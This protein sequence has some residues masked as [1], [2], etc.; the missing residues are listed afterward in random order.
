YLGPDTYLFTRL[1]AIAAAA[2]EAALPTFA[3][4]EAA[5]EIDGVL[6]GLVSRYFEIGQ[7]TGHK[8]A[9]ILRDRVAPRDIPIETLKRFSFVVR[10]D[11]A[12]QIR[13]LPPVAMFNY[14]EMR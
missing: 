13:F 7:F 1:K 10:L 14:A 2:R 11:I 4:T 8:A 5:F 9:R 12:Q 6:A 3:T